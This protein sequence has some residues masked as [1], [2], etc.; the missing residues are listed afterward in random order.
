MI[1]LYI[2]QRNLGGK[3]L[4]PIALYSN[5]EIM[6]GWNLNS[7]NTT[8]CVDY[9]PTLYTV[10]YVTNNSKQIYRD[11]VFYSKSAADLTTINGTANGVEYSYGQENLG[12]GWSGVFMYVLKGNYAAIF[13]LQTNQTVN[14]NL[15]IS[16]FSNT[17][18]PS[19]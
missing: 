15:I 5:V 14:K 8:A 9:C 10:T 19:S 7:T 13:G 11:L 1:I 12:N 4:P 17:I 16:T 6:A 3:F 18:Y 2:H